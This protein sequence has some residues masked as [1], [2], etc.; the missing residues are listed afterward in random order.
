[1]NGNIAWIFDS[2]VKS[3]VPS[4]KHHV[5]TVN[6]THASESNGTGKPSEWELWAI[7]AKGSLRFTLRS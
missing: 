7:S 2:A 1:M 6:E 5:F 3:S 4:Q